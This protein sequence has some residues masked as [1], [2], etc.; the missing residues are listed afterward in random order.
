MRKYHFRY[1]SADKDF[2]I[3]V[4]G[5]SMGDAMIYFATRY[6]DIQEIYTITELPTK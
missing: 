5:N 6:H 4:T 3:L 2:S 1:R